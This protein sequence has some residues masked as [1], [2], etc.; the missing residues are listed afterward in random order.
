MD[1]PRHDPAEQ[2]RECMAAGLPVLPCHWP[3]PAPGNGA[4]WTLP[5]CSCGRR[6]CPTPAAHPL[7][8]LT[9][10][11]ATR[12]L[13]RMTAWWQRWPHANPAVPT[14]G[15]VD[16]VE[17]RHPGP[18]GRVLA[19]LDAQGVGAGPVVRLGVD[20]LVFLTTR[21]ATG[22][23][24]A[25]SPAGEVRYSG[26]GRLVLLPP[27]RLASGG[28]AVWARPPGGPMPAPWPLFRALA[29]LPVAAKLAAFGEP[30]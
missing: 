23:A 6:D 5:R 29:N 8:G 14:D 27:S 1:H 3:V 16:A 9:A 22:T 20:R 17:L 28:Q 13:L 10:A 4:G 25:P 18:D 2:A 21:S 12:S 19:W 30:A 24:F 7:D 15:L 26:D 11:D